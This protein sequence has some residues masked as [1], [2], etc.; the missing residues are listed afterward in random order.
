MIVQM[1]ILRVALF[2]MIV[3]FVPVVALDMMQ[4]QMLIVLVNVLVI[5][6]MMSVRF[7]MVTTVHVINQLLHLNS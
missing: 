5:L 7:A 6:F 2:M 3:V 4:I 1:L